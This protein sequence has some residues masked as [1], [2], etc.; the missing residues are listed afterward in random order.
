MN[1]EHELIETED[2]Y[3]LETE[4]RTYEVEHQEDRDRYVA[5]R[6]GGGKTHV[7]P[8]NSI[9]NHSSDDG[10]LG[11]A[12]YNRIQKNKENS[13]QTGEDDVSSIGLEEENL[14]YL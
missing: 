1:E 3:V 4:S 12:I 11:E 7:L 8:E 14:N 9:A 10:D 5:Q 6:I 2:G 13:S